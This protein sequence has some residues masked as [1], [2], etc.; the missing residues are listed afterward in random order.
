[1]TAPFILTLSIRAEVVDDRLQQQTAET[2]ARMREEAAA[3]LRNEVT[4]R[5]LDRLQKEARMPAQW[6]QLAVRIFEEE[7][8]HVTLKLGEVQMRLIEPAD[9][10]R[11]KLVDPEG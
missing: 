4:Q 1:M 11:P 2:V 10:N 6:A 8:E 9:Q 3:F 5:V 7:T